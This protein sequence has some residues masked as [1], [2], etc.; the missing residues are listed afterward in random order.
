MRERERERESEK[1]RQDT[2]SY[3]PANSQTAL[4][5]I[6]SSSS[7]RRYFGNVRRLDI[8]IVPER[9]AKTDKFP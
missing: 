1:E 7:L 8:L 5:S 2:G 3:R 6:P 9:V 4:D